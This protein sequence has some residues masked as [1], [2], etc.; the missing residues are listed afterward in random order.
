MRSIFLRKQKLIEEIEE[1]NCR[2]KDLNRENDLLKNALQTELSRNDLLRK[3][4]D[5]LKKE[6]L[7]L[8]IKLRNILKGEI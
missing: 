3:E 8:L 1:Q 2:I 5:I 4:N 6:N 7:E